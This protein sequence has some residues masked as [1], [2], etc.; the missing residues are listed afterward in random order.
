MDL[1]TAL[2]YASLAF[3]ISMLWAPLLI[4]VLFKLNVVRNLDKDFS[5]LVGERQLKAGT[6]IMGGLLFVITTVAFTI[7][8]NFNGQ[9]YIPLIVIL[10]SAGLGGFDDL[11]NIFGQK[12]TVRSI[13]KHIKLAK[14]HKSPSK[15]LW[16][17]LTL[18]YN[19]YTNIWYALGSYPNKGLQAGE[20]IIIQILTGGAVAWWLYYE[21]GWQSIQL[22][23][24]GELSLGWLM[25][26]FIIFTV[27][28]MANAVNIADG[29]DGLSSGMAIIAFS[30][31]LMIA[32]TE[33][34]AEMVILISTIIGSLIAY[35]YFNIKPARFQMGDVGSL[36]LGALL[37]VVAFV[38]GKIAL[39]PII[40]FMF[41][42]EI[43]S[44][45]L[46]GVYRRLTGMRLFKM[47]P[48][49]LHFQI[50]GWSEEKTVM[51][52]WVAAAVLALIGLLINYL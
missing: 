16:L 15:R 43:G 4:K 38:L 33:G 51:R 10:L 36:A 19:I 27:V 41:V 28:S 32:L 17:W 2:T 34:K 14:I 21:L 48:L 1:K 42:A 5:A 49:H 26:L 25:P 24:F 52:F 37:A 12:R 40:G 8:T 35:L 39:L 46:Q 50:K 22:P 20:K 44:S 3:F 47:A 9:T 45:L 18:P 7:A 23:L 13:E 30:A 6:P 11:S 31:F 29:M